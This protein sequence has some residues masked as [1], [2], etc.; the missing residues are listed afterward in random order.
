MTDV[1]GGLI[2]LEFALTGLNFG[3]KQSALEGVDLSPR[4]ADVAA[5]IKAATPLIEQLTGPLLPAAK[6]RRYD[7]GKSAILLLEPIANEAAVTSV[8]EDGTAITDFIVDADADI[9]YAGD[10]AG[11]RTFAAGQRNIVVTCQAGYTEIPH[12]LQLA[13]RELVRH[14]YQIGKQ[15]ANPAFDSGTA[16]TP[17][18]PMGFMLPNRVVELCA[19]FR[20]GGF[21]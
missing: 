14:M 20:Q 11:A 15:A 2:T 17:A 6:T 10:H 18:V 4:D 7:G 12:A 5:Y 1:A 9:I 16:D 19:P 21:A 8:T 3:A 13:A